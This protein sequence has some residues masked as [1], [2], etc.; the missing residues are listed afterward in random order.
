MFRNV[1]FVLLLTLT[2]KA[3][4]ITVENGI[5]KKLVV[6]NGF[7]ILGIKNSD[8]EIEVFFDDGKTQTILYKTTPMIKLNRISSNVTVGINPIIYNKYELTQ[9]IVHDGGSGMSEVVPSLFGLNYVKDINATKVSESENSF[10]YT[11]FTSLFDTESNS[12]KVRVI[13]L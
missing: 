13:V 2:V 4:A 10:V 11:L 1:I 6:S 9:I 3:Q 8:F 7:N 5:T 12:I